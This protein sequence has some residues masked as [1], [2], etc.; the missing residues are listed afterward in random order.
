[1]GWGPRGG[2][3]QGRVRVVAPPAAAVRCGRE[4]LRRERGDGGGIRSVA[5]RSNSIGWEGGNACDVS[6]RWDRDADT[7]RAPKKTTFSLRE[8]LTLT[9]A[10]M[11]HPDNHTTQPAQT[12][13]QQNQHPPPAPMHAAAPLPN[14]Q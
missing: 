14:T 1:M 11:Q 4:D 3:R 8:P 12:N 10:P 9:V 6:D 2:G 7:G 5:L 13:H